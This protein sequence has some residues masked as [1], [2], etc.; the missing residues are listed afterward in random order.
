M[1]K[2]SLVE[3]YDKTYR[4]K[5]PVT[6]QPVTTAPATSQPVTS[7]PVTTEPVTSEPLISRLEAIESVS[8]EP[9]ADDMGT[10]MPETASFESKDED[11]EEL[12]LDEAENLEDLAEEGPNFDD[13]L[14]DDESLL[15]SETD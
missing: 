6:T 1:A 13:T 14:A 11:I 10:E 15:D 5:S 2:T 3:W 9:S 4:N 8:S 12:A 7:T